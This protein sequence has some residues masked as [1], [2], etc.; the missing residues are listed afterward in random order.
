MT[1]SLPRNK[2]YAVRH[3]VTNKIWSMDGHGYMWLWPSVQSIRDAWKDAKEVGLV[4]GDLTDHHIVTI[5]LME[6]S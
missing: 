5:E 2:M 3:G 4:K 1:L 6:R